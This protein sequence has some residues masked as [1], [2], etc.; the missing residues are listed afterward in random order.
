MVYF[1]FAGRISRLL[2]DGRMNYKSNESPYLEVFKG[3]SQVH[4]IDICK[5]LN[6]V[7][8]ELNFI[9]RL[10][11]YLQPA[12]SL[13][14]DGDI[15]KYTFLRQVLPWQKRLQGR[16]FSIISLSEF[17]YRSGGW[18]QPFKEFWSFL[19][20]GKNNRS[21]FFH[22]VNFVEKFPRLN[23]RFFKCLY[24]FNLLDGVFCPD[25]RLVESL[26]RRRVFF[27]PELIATNLETNIS[28]EK[29]SFY[30]RIKS[31][32]RDFLK[33][34]PGKHVLL[35]F[36]D[37]ESRKGYDLLLQLAVHDPDCV[38]VR[39]GRTK[40]NYTSNWEATLS[41]EK[42]LLENRL[43]EVDTYIE[44]QGLTDYIFS[45]V[46]F[47]VL[48]YRKYYRAS[49][50]LIDVLRRGLPVLTSNKGVM[51]YIVK[52]YRVGK[53]FCDGH[54]RELQQRFVDFKQNYKIYSKNIEKFNIAYS[55][56]N[57]DEILSVML[58]G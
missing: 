10:Q 44:S 15:L 52:Y 11:H 20:M 13:F 28:K 35:M 18:F 40:G 12:V 55:Q 9:I 17:I 53:V 32:Y 51:A 2:P 1:C 43:F 54:F 24:R 27:L 38:C 22:R 50:V 30:S 29:A 25:I 47:M 3:N 16:N 4:F 39:F 58:K 31:D 41:K 6:K 57:I 8:N 21:V 33:K 42:L 46:R 19:F 56:K 48:P 34:N 14:I 37:L 5:E 26:R 36:G 45:T 49:G 7:K 23:Q